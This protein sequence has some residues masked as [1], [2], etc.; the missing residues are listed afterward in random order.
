MIKYKTIEA[1]DRKSLEALLNKN[2]FDAFRKLKNWRR[3]D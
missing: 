3:N 2:E 1:S